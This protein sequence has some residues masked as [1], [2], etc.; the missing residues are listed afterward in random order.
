ML[1][2]MQVARMYDFNHI[3]VERMAI[4]K[5]GAG[6]ILVRMEACGICSGELMP[7]YVRRKVPFVLGHEPVGI[8]HE[9]GSEVREFGP[10]DRVFVHHHAPC[11]KCKACRQRRYVQCETWKR[12]KLDPGGM[13]EFVRVPATNVQ[14]DTLKIPAGLSVDHGIFV[15]PLGCV[16]KSLRRANLQS[17]DTVL[18][19]GAG[20]MGLLHVQLARYLGAACIIVADSVPLRLQKASRLGAHRV[21]NVATE[22]LRDTVH[23]L[24]G[25]D[26]AE[27]VIVG[28]GFI[29]AMQSGLECCA[30]GG[31]VL[32]FAPAPPD[33]LWSISP[34]DI[35][36]N[37]ISLVP[38]YSC[39]P[40]DTREALKLLSE[41]VIAVHELITHRFPLSQIEQA[42]KVAQEP[43]ISLKVAIAFN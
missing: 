41:D 11:L 34:H 7:W 4:P 38:S 22:N 36:F 21:V 17:G 16:V 43:D 30:P 26:L 5:I 29:A 13:A 42:F 40:N 10:G 24:T 12:T 9:I 20:V 3:C 32:L 6:E 28:P 18:V 37:E 35:Y 31:T 23:K 39:G 25:G 14:H 27:I 19:I 2:S 1:V 33:A 15:E 8:V